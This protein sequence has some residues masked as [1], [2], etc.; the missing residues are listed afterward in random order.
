MKLIDIVS[1][2]M[3]VT[4]LMDLDF[5]YRDA[6]ALVMLKN[7]LQPQA[8]FFAEKERQLM[9]E[10]GDKGEDGAVKPDAGGKFGISDP[11]RLAEYSRKRGELYAL[12]TDT[13]FSRRKMTAPKTIRPAQLA[14]LM[15]F[16]DFK[17]AENADTS[18]K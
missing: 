12:D 17:E 8:E 14:A 18:G 16:M 4:Q 3:A 7:E 5:G 10:Y 1:A 2:Y 13:V 9:E 15:P 11:A 6:Y